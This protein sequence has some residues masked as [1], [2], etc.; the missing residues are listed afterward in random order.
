M[1]TGQEAEIGLE[2][3]HGHI[4]CCHHGQHRGH[5]QASFLHPSSH[6]QLISPGLK[7]FHTLDHGIGSHGAGASGAAPHHGTCLQHR[8]W[9]RVPAAEFIPPQPQAG[10]D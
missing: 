2:R 5:N 3:L 1:G 8:G 6:L 4:C 9:N 10:R 7:F